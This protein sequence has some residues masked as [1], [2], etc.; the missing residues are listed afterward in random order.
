M[1]QVTGRN[2]P[3][4]VTG[5]ATMPTAHSTDSSGKLH[6]CSPIPRN[7]ARR[8]LGRDAREPVS[9]V[10][11][12]SSRLHPACRETPARRPASVFR[13]LSSVFC[14]LNSEFCLLDSGFF[15]PAPDPP[16]TCTQSPPA[17][18]RPVRAN[19]AVARRPDSPSIHRPARAAPRPRRCGNP[20]TR[21]NCL[22]GT[23]PGCWPANA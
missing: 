10:K 23:A 15:L 16:P 17:P 19:G 21:D 20:P 11:N 1:L 2:W 7:G 4:V 5:P 18:A 12:R 22:P 14:L 9:G 6:R 13:I 8:E 3:K